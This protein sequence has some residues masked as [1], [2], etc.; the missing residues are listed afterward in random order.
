MPGRSNP[1]RPEADRI[2][3]E[4]GPD[5][6][7]AEPR[8]DPHR[9]IHGGRILVIR[10]HSVIEE[11]TASTILIAGQRR[12][13]HPHPIISDITVP[14]VT[15]R[16]V[17]PHRSPA[18]VSSARAI[19]SAREPPASWVTDSVRLTP[20][21][22]RPCAVSRRCSRPLHSVK[23]VHRCRSGDAGCPA[24]TSAAGPAGPG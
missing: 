22:V 7:S 5:E 12:L 14:R 18:R 15:P 17:P 13:V 10:H 9:G 6:G 19:V 20:S 8:P 24:P 16:R 21:S 2:G 1:G 23:P 4:V 11:S 3:S